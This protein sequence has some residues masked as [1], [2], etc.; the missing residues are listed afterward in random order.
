MIARIERSFGMGDKVGEEITAATKFLRKRKRQLNGQ[1][2]EE[3]V[4]R[5]TI[6]GATHL[7]AKAEFYGAPNSLDKPNIEISLSDQDHDDNTHLPYNKILTEKE[8]L[9]LWD[10]MLN[11]IR[12]RTKNQ[13]GTGSIWG[14]GPGKK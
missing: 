8:F 3:L 7:D 4:M 2:G 9:A 1:D 11:S 5:I 6:D 14:P 13:T 10:T 12:P